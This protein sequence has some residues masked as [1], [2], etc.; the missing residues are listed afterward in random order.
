MTA[1]LQNA[2]GSG[3]PVLLRVEAEAGHGAGRPLD[4]TLA[5]QTDVWSFL[6]WQLGV[7]T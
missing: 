6:C 4:K 7:S 2:S 5:E 3:L 1:R